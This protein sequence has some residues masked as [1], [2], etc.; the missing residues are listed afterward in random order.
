MQSHVHEKIM[1]WTP[2]KD[3]LV[4]PALNQWSIMS[5]VGVIITIL[6]SYIEHLF[7]NNCLITVNHCTEYS[8]FTC[9]KYFD[10]KCK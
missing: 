9:I 6:I 4:A 1:Q 7:K 3:S 5:I 8:M 2:P 10:K